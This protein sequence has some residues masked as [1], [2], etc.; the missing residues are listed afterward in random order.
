MRVNKG[1]LSKITGLSQKPRIIPAVFEA[2]P[3]FPGM[4]PRKTSFRVYPEVLL[5]YTVTPY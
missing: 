5:T 3:K 1:F 4:N 2:V